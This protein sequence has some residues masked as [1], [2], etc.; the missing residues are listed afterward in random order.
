MLMLI[1]GEIDDCQIK[2][3]FWIGGIDFI[4]EG[5]WVWILIQKNLIYFYWGYDEFNGNILENCV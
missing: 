4:V 3:S 1:I 2:F 5:Q